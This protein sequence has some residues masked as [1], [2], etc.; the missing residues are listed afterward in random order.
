MYKH[1]LVPLDGS[2][3]GS[4]ALRHAR[5]LALKFDSKVTL[6]RVVAPSRVTTAGLGGPES[7][8]A[9]EIVFDE[10]QRADATNLS[11]AKA[12][13]AKHRRAL[14][15]AG[16]TEAVTHGE[17]GSAP[18][19]ILAYAKRRKADLIVMTTR[20]RS[21]IARAFLG[22]VADELVRSAVAPVLV[23]KRQD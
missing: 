14:E 13:L 4:L 19:V 23:I 1:I 15:K 7:L 2:R 9:A 6:L 18:D 5:Q 22:S 10:A 21:G 20:G 8:A 3:A 12:Y 17:V 16:V 11:Q